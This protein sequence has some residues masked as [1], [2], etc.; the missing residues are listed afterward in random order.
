MEL[1]SQKFTRAEI[2]SQ[3]GVKGKDATA[4]MR[5]LMES[6]RLIYQMDAVAPTRSNKRERRYC[7]VATTRNMAI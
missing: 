3:L 7:F 4:A 2:E 5:D 1:M 6:G